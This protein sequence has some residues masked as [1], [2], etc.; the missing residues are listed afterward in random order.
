MKIDCDVPC[1]LDPQ[2]IKCVFS[3]AWRQ[4]ARSTG[5]KHPVP[6]RISKV[7][8]RKGGNPAWCPRMQR[9]PYVSVH[10]YINPRRTMREH[11]LDWFF[12][13][14]GTSGHSSFSAIE[15]APFPKAPK[16][17][18]RAKREPVHVERLA[19]ARSRVEEWTK[20]HAD[21]QRAL[22]LAKTKLR[23]YKAQVRALER[24]V[25]KTAPAQ[26]IGYDDKAFA[27]HMRERIGGAT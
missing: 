1:G 12:A 26:S 20:K 7:R 23:R 19:E 3:E 14:G 18:K 2:A 21:A 22:R 24:E 6:K 10:V 4:A 8:A 16:K 5:W 13:L 9:T 11:A 27:A 17:A 15:D 25:K